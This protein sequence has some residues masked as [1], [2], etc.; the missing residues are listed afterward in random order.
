MHCGE[1]GDLFPC[2]KNCGHLDC[3]EA[4]SRKCHK[5]GKSIGVTIGKNYLVDGQRANCYLVHERCAGDDVFVVE[6][7]EQ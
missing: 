3:A 5:C 2:D 4:K 7:D 1:C 6:I